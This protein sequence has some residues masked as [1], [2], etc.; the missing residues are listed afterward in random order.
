MNLWIHLKQEN[1]STK[2]LNIYQ[3]QIHNIIDKA[4]MKLAKRYDVCGV[5]TNNMEK[6]PINIFN[7]NCIPKQ[8][9]VHFNVYW[10]KGNK[11]LH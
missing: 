6:V 9:S 7:I 11:G 4:F 2:F 8:I 5:Q 3:T 10:G 1:M